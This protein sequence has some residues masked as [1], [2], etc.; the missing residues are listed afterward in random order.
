MVLSKPKKLLKI[1]KFIKALQRYIHH[2]CILR[3]SDSTR[4]APDLRSSCPIFR[5]LTRNSVESNSHYRTEQSIYLFFVRQSCKSGEWVSNNIKKIQNL[6]EFSFCSHT[7]V[8]EI[9][10]HNIKITQDNILVTK[11]KRGEN[12]C[13]DE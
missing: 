6:V 2:T 8:D 3:D 11:N 7:Y 9:T 5:I 13:I 10:R 12:A 4:I 1:K